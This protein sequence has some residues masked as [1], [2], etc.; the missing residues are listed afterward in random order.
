MDKKKGS[1]DLPSIVAQDYNTKLDIFNTNMCVKNVVQRYT[2]F[3][4]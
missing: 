3:M 2:I 4:F 1:D